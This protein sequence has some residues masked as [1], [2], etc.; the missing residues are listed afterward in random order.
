V[1]DQHALKGD[2][3]ENMREIKIAFD[4]PELLHGGKWKRKQMPLVR[5]PGIASS[6]R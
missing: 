4:R 2:R 5:L 6:R 1:P 3:F